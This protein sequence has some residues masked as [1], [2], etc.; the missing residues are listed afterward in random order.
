M[1]NIKVEPRCPIRT[2]MELVGGKWRLL[3]L[4]QLREENLRT[5][6]IRRRIDGIS[7]K[8]LIRELKA[9]VVQQLI[10]RHD[11][12]EQPPRVE[13]EIT[14]KGLTALPLIKAMKAF[15]DDY[16]MADATP[17]KKASPIV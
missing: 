10:V 13:Y 2:T 8:V 12:S 15:S 5:S 4:F 16:L 7:E 11:F 17:A 1:E 14:E 9:L 6:E 3:I